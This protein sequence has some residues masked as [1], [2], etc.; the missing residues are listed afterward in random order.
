MVGFFYYDH[1]PFHIIQEWNFVIGGITI[2]SSVSMLYRVLSQSVCRVDLCKTWFH[3]FL[4][5]FWCDCIYALG[6][7]TDIYT[8]FSRT[9]R[10]LHC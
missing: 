3:K 6:S 5:L 9:L 1:E 2:N 7:V 10:V 8:C 4:C